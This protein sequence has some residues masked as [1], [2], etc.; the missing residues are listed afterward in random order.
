MCLL[1]QT[2][3][4]PKGFDDVQLLMAKIMLFKLMKAV[5]LVVLQACR[6]IHQGQICL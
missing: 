2:A 3:T 4:C 5:T 6:Q 1:N